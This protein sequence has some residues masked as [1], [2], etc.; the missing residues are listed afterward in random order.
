MILFLGSG[1]TK[2]PVS[3]KEKRYT[4]EVIERTKPFPCI[5]QSSGHYFLSFWVPKTALFLFS[6]PDAFFIPY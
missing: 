2:Q 1:K 6:F 5:C 3:R 4:K